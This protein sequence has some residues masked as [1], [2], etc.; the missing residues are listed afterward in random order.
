MKPITLLL[1]IQVEVDWPHSSQQA[2]SW[3]RIVAVNLCTVLQVASEYFQDCLCDAWFLYHHLGLP[4]ARFQVTRS[5]SQVFHL[6][7]QYHRLS[8][9]YR[10]H[11]SYWLP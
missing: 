3:H 6:N 7:I 2:H 9:F 5:P 1:L 4:I 8:L 10:T 11:H